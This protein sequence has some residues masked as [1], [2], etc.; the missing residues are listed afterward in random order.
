MEI[1]MHIRGTCFLKSSKIVLP[2]PISLGIHEK[3][4]HVKFGAIMTMIKHNSGFA[5]YIWIYFKWRQK[6]ICMMISRRMAIILAFYNCLNDENGEFLK[7]KE[8]F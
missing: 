3:Q 8:S 4:P 5:A 6:S 1:G 7:W 2:A